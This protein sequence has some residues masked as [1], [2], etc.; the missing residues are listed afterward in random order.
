MS[1]TDADKKWWHPVPQ[2]VSWLARQIPPG[3]KVLE[4]G[5]SRFQFPRATT[6]VDFA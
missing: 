5:P 3:A 1:L 2:V 4:I 6:F